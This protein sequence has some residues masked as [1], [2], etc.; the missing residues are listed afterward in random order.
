MSTRNAELQRLLARLNG[1]DNTSMTDASHLGGRTAPG[2]TGLKAESPIAL[3]NRHAYDTN[4]VEGG[5]ENVEVSGSQSGLLRLTT[6]SKPAP[7]ASTITTWP[8]A[9]KHVTKYLMNDD[10]F[11]AR[12]KHLISE[13]YKHEEQWWNQRQEI[14]N[15]HSNRS[16]NQ[17]KVAGILKELGGLAMPMVK[18][19]EAADKNELEAFDKKVYKSMV[20]MT[21]NFD[22]QL[23]KLGV[24]FYAIK[25]EL[26]ILDHEKQS[27]SSGKLDKGELRELQKRLI[28]HLE[29][30][31]SD[32]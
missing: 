5:R 31:L 30:L 16:G 13:Q 15:R 17:L 25:H 28:Q 26:V 4:H 29:D 18:V 32:D 11:T 19:D 7:D 1:Q 21:A 3:V 20:Q 23:R 14:I 27:N 8:A 2:L 9:L 12:V 24:P 10:Q 6:P 22:G